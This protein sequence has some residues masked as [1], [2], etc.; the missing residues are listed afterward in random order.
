MNLI[1]SVTVVSMGSVR[2]LRKSLQHVVFLT[3]I[4]DSV[5]W[6][7]LCVCSRG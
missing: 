3:L 6:L 5:A 2:V 4:A 7:Q 1:P